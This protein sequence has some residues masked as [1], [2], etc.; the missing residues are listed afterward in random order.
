MIAFCCSAL[1]DC[2]T[3]IS[4]GGIGIGITET[5]SGLETS[6]GLADSS[7]LCI[8]AVDTGLEYVAD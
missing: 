4:V 1:A 7:G 3:V 2:L 6:I 8:V 5:L